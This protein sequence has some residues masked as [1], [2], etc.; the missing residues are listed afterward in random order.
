MARL[1][2]TGGTGYGAAGASLTKRGVKAFNAVSSSPQS[3]INDN[4]MTLRQRCRMLYMSAPI[5][6]SAINTNRTKVVGVGLHP[7]PSINR[8]IL[9][10][11]EEQAVA[12][13]RHTLAEW[14]MFASKKQ[15][16][17]AL[18]NNNFYELQQIALKSWLMS[19]DVFCLIKRKP[20]EKMRPYTLRLQL[21]EADRVCTPGVMAATGITTAEDEKTKHKIF[22]GV[23][24]DK[25]GCV[26]AYHIC[27]GYPGECIYSDGND[28]TRVTA[29]GGKTGLPN[30]LHIKE[31]ERPDQYRGVSILAPCIEM[32]LQMRRYT[33]AELTAAIIQSYLTAWIVKN[34]P[35]I[36]GNPIAN[37]MDDDS[38][39]GVDKEKVP[40][41]EVHGYTEQQ[42]GPG[43]ILMLDEGE[44]VKF[45]NPNIPTEGFESFIKTLSKM[46]GAGLELPYDVLIKEFN[47]S[48][49]AAKGAL[50]EAWEVIKMRREHLISD[51]CNPV[52]EMWLAEAVA[53]GRIK[54]PGFFENPLIRLAWSGV[55]WDGPAQIHLDPVKEAE[56]NETAVDRRWKTNE[57]VAREYY[58]TDWR[59]NAERVSQENKLISDLLPKEGV[60]DGNN[61]V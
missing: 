25:D 56:A 14:N 43:N 42:M 54:A 16:V 13:Q 40:Q 11:N 61:D 59:E 20:A 22:D 19:G 55:R 15:N 60:I 44:D 41:E 45:G 10:M 24:V 9:G 12:W 39:E 35:N 4:N 27:K 34:T 5:A 36:T 28:W 53:S 33:E 37:D 51:F 1:I 58:G 47:A 17:D 30:I 8:D 46:C 26:V 32:V 31:D 23:E 57:Q 18:G 2:F 3:D 38:F 48:Y 50:E 52:Y 29:I 7:S 6:T 21:V 49:S